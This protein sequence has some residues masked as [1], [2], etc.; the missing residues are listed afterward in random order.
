MVFQEAVSEAGSD[1][2]IL[3]VPQ[4]SGNRTSQ[5]LL[6]RFAEAPFYLI[7]SAVPGTT[8]F[9]QQILFLHFY[10]SFEL[11]VS[12][13]AP[14]STS[15]RLF[16]ILHF[17]SSLQTHSFGS[18]FVF[19]IFAAWHLFIPRRPQKTQK[20]PR[21]PEK[22]QKDT[23]KDTKSHPKRSEKTQKDPRRPE[24]TRENPKRP[25]KTSKNCLHIIVFDKL[26]A[27]A[28]IFTE[29]KSYNKLKSYGCFKP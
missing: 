15:L 10:S 24:K 13:A 5:L 14:F 17:C 22:T 4:F 3:K 6:L 2:L 29:W 25:E 11:F 20:D 8:T 16:M 28:S 1:N 27:K 26:C 12:A 9:L 19:Y 18:S 21:R 7:A 23:W